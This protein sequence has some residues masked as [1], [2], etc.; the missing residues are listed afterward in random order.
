MALPFPF[1]TSS[2]SYRQ[3]VIFIILSKYTFKSLQYLRN[4][5]CNQVNAD[6]EEEVKDKVKEDVKV[7]DDAK[8]VDPVEPP[9]NEDAVENEAPA[10]A[11]DEL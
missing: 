5:F 6:G 1:P 10:E 11:K 9:T 8:K 3:F 7:P 4:F 2:K